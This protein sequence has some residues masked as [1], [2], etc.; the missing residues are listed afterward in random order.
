MS[1]NK[2]VAQ[3]DIFF[4]KAKTELIVNIRQAGLGLDPPVVED[5]NCDNPV[6][7][8]VFRQVDISP[9]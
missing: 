4:R 2:T 7:R 5:I 8:I 6:H 3:N 1:L 9:G